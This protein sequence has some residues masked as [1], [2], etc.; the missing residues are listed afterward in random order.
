RRQPAERS[1]ARCERANA[2]PGSPLVAPGFEP[3]WTASVPSDW[4][5]H[6]DSW[7]L[8]DG[9]TA[10]GDWLRERCRGADW[11]PV[12]T[13]SK[14]MAVERHIRVIVPGDSPG[15]I[16][17]THLESRLASPRPLACRSSALYLLPNALGC[18]VASVGEQPLRKVYFPRFSGGCRPIVDAKE[19]M[20]ASPSICWS[21]RIVLRGRI[22][23]RAVV[24]ERTL[25][26][27]RVWYAC[28][29]LRAEPVRAALGNPGRRPAGG[30]RPGLP[31][32]VYGASPAR[33]LARGSL[34]ADDAHRLIHGGRNWV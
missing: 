1:R 19:A 18:G 28:G 2:I 13:T 33:D 21:R 10:L 31:F 9:T 27:S 22:R 24:H 12:A 25:R 3:V 29:H 7:S 6:Q 26:V 16:L 5:D 17:V 4:R 15:A 32:V 30:V 11:V 14:L 8:A 23:N 20:V 34:P